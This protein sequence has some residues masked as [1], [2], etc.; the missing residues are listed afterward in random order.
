MGSKDILPRLGVSVRTGYR[1]AP[2]NTHNF[3]DQRFFRTTLYL[4]GLLKHQSIKLNLSTEK[5]N[6]ERYI[7]ANET[8]LPRGYN[9]IIGLDVKVLSADY[10]FPLLYPDL[11]IGPVLYI[12]RVRGN[13]WADNLQ[14]RDMLVTDPEP[15]LVDRNYFSCGA[16]L[17]F[18]LHVLRF[19]FPFSLG[20]RVAYL[21]EPGEWKQEFLFSI[22][23]N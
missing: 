3:G 8:S 17:L 9:D 2:W 15:A 10:N 1:H 6:P 4:P 7:F 19:M 14:G 23:I 22:D 18:D 20:A 13:L 21:P 11:N 5:Q 12:K 16:D